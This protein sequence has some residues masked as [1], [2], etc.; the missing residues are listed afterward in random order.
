VI[1]FGPLPPVV[2]LE[3]DAG[4]GSCSVFEDP[5][6]LDSAWV[7]ATSPELFAGAGSEVD[8][9]PGES[10]GVA[11]RSGGEMRVWVGSGAGAGVGVGTIA[12]DWM[13][14]AG[15]VGLACAPDGAGVLARGA[16][17]AA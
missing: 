13:G 16:G 17:A 10:G 15:R 8:R 1:F 14:C 5:G 6:T 4:T 3:D 9:V 2:L 12:G 11:V 7:R